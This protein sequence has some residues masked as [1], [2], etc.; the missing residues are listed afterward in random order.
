MCCMNFFRSPKCV[1]AGLLRIGFG[2]TLLLIGLSE[3]MSLAEFQVSL[4]GGLGPLVPLGIAVA[5]AVPGLMMLGGLLL[6]A[7]LFPAV[8]VLAAG[9]SLIIIPVIALLKS[10]IS[11]VPLEDVMPT[12]LNSFLWLLVYILMVKSSYGCCGSLCSS[13]EQADE[14]CSTK[15]KRK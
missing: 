14:C 9:L 3:A 4:A 2:L 8:S 7:D 10:M 6:I 11:H 15:K 12:V 5:Y 1:A 13:K